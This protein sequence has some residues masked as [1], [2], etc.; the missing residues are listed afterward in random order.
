MLMNKRDYKQFACG[1]IFHIYDCQERPLTYNELMK[2]RDYKQ[3]A[4][5]SIF[6]VYNRGNNREDVFQDE[7]DFRAF[8]FRLGL[9]LG[10]ESEELNEHPLTSVPYSRVRITNMKKNCFKIHSFCLMGNHFHLLI[11]QCSDLSISKLILKVC[12]SYSMFRNKKYRRIGHV[13]QDRFKAILI[14]S[15]AQLMWTSAYIHM[16]P[17]KDRLVN[18]PSKYKWSSY[19]DYISERNLPITHT[20]FLTSTFVDKKN[21][22]KQTLDFNLSRGALDSADFSSL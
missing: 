21:F 4:K 1:S 12:T 8:L 17:I 16:N 2:N 22:E 6:H 18:H 11:E 5:G 19:N 7:E 10:F 13:F 3:F 14:E 20:D 9:G 15:D